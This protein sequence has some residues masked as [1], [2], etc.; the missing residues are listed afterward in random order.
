MRLWTVDLLEVEI[1]ALKDKSR[2]RDLGPPW[3]NTLPRLPRCG[4]P[5]GWDY[6][7]RPWAYMDAPN[8]HSD[9]KIK[10]AHSP[11]AARVTIAVLV[12]CEREPQFFPNLVVAKL[13]AAAPTWHGHQARVVDGP[14]NL[15]P[16]ITM[17]K[18]PKI[19]QPPNYSGP[20]VAVEALFNMWDS[21]CTS[22]TMWRPNPDMPRGDATLEG[23]LRTLT[24]A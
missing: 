1:S 16:K 19:V 3:Q 17:P 21:F 15:H 24:A 9:I 5:N 6:W 2:P 20:N 12:N 11:R 7:G 13:A 14:G 8:G 23:C 18:A 10:S 4:A 22:K